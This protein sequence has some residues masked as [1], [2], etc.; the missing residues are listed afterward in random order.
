MCDSVC[1]CV[2]VFEGVRVSLCVRMCMCMH[3]LLQMNYCLYMCAYASLHRSVYSVL[4]CVSCVHRL[5]MQVFVVC[6]WLAGECINQLKGKHF[7]HKKVCQTFFQL[8]MLNN[9]YYRP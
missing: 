1:D 5:R 7:Y 6:A 8:M 9:T 2:C 4:A 3:A